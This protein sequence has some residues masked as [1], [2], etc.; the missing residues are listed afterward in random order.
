MDESQT[1]V[2]KVLV[3]CITKL[4]SD[5]AHMRLVGLYRASGN[6]A[7]IQKLRFKI[8][9]NNYRALLEQTDANNITGIVKLFF[10]EL[11]A[12]LVSMQCIGTVISDATV[13][14]GKDDDDWPKRRGGV[15]LMRKLA[16]VIYFTAKPVREQIADIARLY[17][18]LPSIN[19]ATLKYFIEHVAHVERI[20]ENEMNVR[21]LAMVCGACICY[22]SV[23]SVHHGR[24][25]DAFVLANK[26]VELMI[27]HHRE[28][29]H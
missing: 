17:T 5:P 29:F 22:E 11:K 26:C 19:R 28:V 4:E 15:L 18:L 23:Q 16:T 12:P 25:P 27:L 10:R 21:S 7:T 3:E 14:F 24:N 9:A 2:P 1:L 8:D 13:F 6:H 20:P